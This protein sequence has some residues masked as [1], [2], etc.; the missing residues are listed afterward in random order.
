MAANQ[1]T[2]PKA[3]LSYELRTKNYDINNSASFRE[4]R[5]FSKTL[6]LPNEPNFRT[7]QIAT[8]AF[9]TTGYCS[10]MTENCQKNEPKRTQSGNATVSVA[11]NYYRITQVQFNS[12]LMNLSHKYLNLVLIRVHSWFKKITNEPNFTRTFLHSYIHKF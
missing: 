2:I 10:L 3:I 9:S 11:R 12:T 8:S 1:N 6:F 7:S 5:G 4:F